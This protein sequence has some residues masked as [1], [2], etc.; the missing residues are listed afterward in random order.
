LAE[1]DQKRNTY[2]SSDVVAPQVDINDDD[3]DDD[4]CDVTG[5]PAADAKTSREQSSKQQYIHFGLENALLGKSLGVV[6]HEQY[7]S[8]IRTLGNEYPHAIPARFKKAFFPE[9]HQADKVNRQ[10]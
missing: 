3:D 9:E 8:I 7:C 5:I 10:T 1:F 6:H 4:D 2:P